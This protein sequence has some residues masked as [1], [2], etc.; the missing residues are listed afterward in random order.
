MALRM[1]H[2]RQQTGQ[3]R[4]IVALAGP[5]PMLPDIGIFAAI[6]AVIMEV[7]R[8][9]I[10]LFTALFAVKSGLIRRVHVINRFTPV[11]GFRRQSSEFYSFVNFLNVPG[12]LVI[13]H[14][15][16]IQNEA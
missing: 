3:P 16:P 9:K 11:W 7:I 4:Q 15:S 1:M 14:K 13:L 10:N 8:R 2:L 12:Y 5:V 6:H